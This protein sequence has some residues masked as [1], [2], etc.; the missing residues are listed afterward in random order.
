MLH[1]TGPNE[2]ET[3]RTA[4]V[5]EY[6]PLADYDYA[7]TGPFFIAA[8][9]GISKPHFVETQVGATP[10]NQRRY[11]KESAARSVAQPIRKLG[12]SLKS[13]MHAPD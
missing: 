5:V 11:W 6:M 4:F 13:M 9:G 8:E 12:A 3:A 7:A 10:E 2:A 1:R